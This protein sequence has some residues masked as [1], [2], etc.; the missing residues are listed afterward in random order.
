MWRSARRSS[1]TGALGK[2]TVGLEAGHLAKQGA[3]AAAL[4][5]LATPL[6]AILALVNPGLA[7]DADCSA[8]L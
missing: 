1:C 6:A 2:P 7:K 3:E 4:G 8:L 5:A